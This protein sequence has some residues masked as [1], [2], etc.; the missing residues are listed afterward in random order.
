MKS[1]ASSTA[2]AI[3]HLQP[4]DSTRHKSSRQHGGTEGNIPGPA[5]K[6]TL[7]AASWLTRVLGSC[8]TD[9]QPH[10][11]EHPR[12]RRRAGLA[13]LLWQRKHLNNSRKHQTAADKWLVE[14]SNKSD[15]PGE[16]RSMAGDETPTHR[17]PVT[18][19]KFSCSS[20]LC[21]SAGAGEP[22]PVHVTSHELLTQC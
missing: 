1:V 15:V 17:Q 6:T 4:C 3:S 12:P 20:L 16:P 22:S 21:S 13:S 8:R 14:M 2:P 18:L 10:P 9:A 7:G 5:W 19:G 11:A